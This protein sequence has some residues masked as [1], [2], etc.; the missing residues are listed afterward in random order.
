MAQAMM[1]MPNNSQ[2][3][4]PIP[5]TSSPAMPP[6]PISQRRLQ[7][8][9]SIPNVTNDDNNYAD[10]DYIETQL[11]QGSPEKSQDRERSTSVTKQPTVLYSQANEVPHG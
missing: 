7:Q 5:A 10:R 8:H 4:L 3:Q 2:Q 6:S 9:A 1:Q 11:S